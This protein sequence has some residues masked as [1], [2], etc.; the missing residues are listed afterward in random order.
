MVDKIKTSVRV[1]VWTVS[2]II[3]LLLAAFSWSSLNVKTTQEL[4]SGVE[5][6]ADNIELNYKNIKDHEKDV[7]R[8]LDKKASKEKVNL[9]YDAIIRLEDKFDKYA[10]EHR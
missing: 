6:N 4:R 5:T 9:T 2:L 1:P 3:T 10:S 8:A 7:L